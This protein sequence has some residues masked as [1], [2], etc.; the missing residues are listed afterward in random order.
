MTVLI[1]KV[2]PL[3]YPYWNKRLTVLAYHRIVSDQEFLSGQAGVAISTS[4]SEFAR[5]M[6]LVKTHFSPISMENLQQC[7]QGQI[8]LPP[9]PLLITF[10]DGYQDIQ[11]HALPVLEELSIPATVFL[12]S[13]YMGSQRMFQWDTVAY[14]FT[15]TK[16]S[17]A[18]LPLLGYC[19]WHSEQQR[20]QVLKKWLAASKQCQ[21]TERQAM[22]KTL[23]NV[24]QVS[25]PS[26]N[27]GAT[28][29][30]SWE[31]VRH[32][33]T[34]LFTF[35]SHTCTHPILSKIPLEQVISEVQ[36]SKQKIEQ[37][38]GHEVFSFAYP[39]GL[40]TDFNT[41]VVDILAKSGYQL[42]FSLLPGPELM[43][44]IKKNPLEIFR[45]T[46]TTKDNYLRFIFKLMGLVR[47]K[48]RLKG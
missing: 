36:Q 17:A 9:R 33:S 4:V 41:E 15:E 39:N 34:K 10:D 2:L 5:Q 16:L 27:K 46:V 21:D 13:D 42:A 19:V 18:E 14:C 40:A 24:L 31:Q 12:A 25:L 45:V 6:C 35:G 47:F 26:E 1:E 44:E 3:Y 28:S 7:L 8:A 20:Q 30:L 48:A 37:E 22:T 43:T 32:L 23:A 38:T 11:T 29:F